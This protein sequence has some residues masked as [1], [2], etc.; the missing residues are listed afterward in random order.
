MRASCTHRPSR[1][2]LTATSGRLAASKKPASKGL[3][4]KKLDKVDDALFEQVGGPLC[5]WGGVLGQ[6]APPW[7][8]AVTP[9]AG[10]REQGA[11]L[12]PEGGASLLTS[13]ATAASPA[14]QR[15]ARPAALP[16][17]MPAPRARRRPRPSRWRRPSRW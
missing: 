1:P 17:P 2:P 3:G 12:R 10:S 9:A 14:A 15:S 13:V 11:P 8:V 6:A 4:L 16:D 5:G 7:A